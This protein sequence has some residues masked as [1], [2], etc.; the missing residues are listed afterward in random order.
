[1][2]VEVTRSHIEKGVRGTGLGMY[3]PI[4]LAL[5]DAT[6]RNCYIAPTKILFY[7]NDKGTLSM[8]KLP[9]KVFDALLGWERGATLEPFSFE[10]SL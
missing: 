4:C 6:K 7:T 8:S 5:D 9:E 3:S 10:V 2:I 1:V